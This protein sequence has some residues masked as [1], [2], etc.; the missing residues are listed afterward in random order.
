MEDATRI[1]LKNRTGL[2]MSPG[3]SQELLEATSGGDFA[4]T[5]LPDADRNGLAETR[6]EYLAEA[7]PLGSVPAPVTPVGMVQSAAKMLT[8]ARLQVLMDK[9]A[10][11]AAFERS[12][13]RLYDALLAKHRG[14]LSGAGHDSQRADHV[15]HQTLLEFRR[16]EAAHFL[17]VSDAITQLGGD[18]TAQTP[19]ADAVGVMSMG[20][21]QTVSDPRTSLA[22]SVSAILTAELTDVASWDLLA[23]LAHAM[24][25]DEMARDF[26][27]AMEHEE[28]HLQVIRQW[29]AQLVLGESGK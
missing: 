24:G 1:S 27:A 9:L 21:V 5:S 15:P 14:E 18:P 13:V 10:E 29:H 22:Q 25:Q 19:C 28:H 3:D 12:G 17:L 8:G 11:R 4:S 6:A 2:Q 20:L 26:R 16:Q 23:R 7:G